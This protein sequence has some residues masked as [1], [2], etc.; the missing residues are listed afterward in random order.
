[1]K[2]KGK[3]PLHMKLMGLLICLTALTFLVSCTVRQTTRATRVRLVSVEQAHMCED[4]CEFLGN[5]TGYSCWFMTR[6]FAHNNALHELQDN[7]VELGATHVFVNRGAKRSL[8]GEAYFC[9]FCKDVDGKPIDSYCLDEEGNKN[10]TVD[11]E[12]CSE[13]EHTWVSKPNSREKCERREG[14]WVPNE[15]MLRREESATIQ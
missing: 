4:E 14:T 5:V 1:M 2:N 9:A 13:K 10:Y 15:D 6:G 12:I 7:A 8:R 11:K 3:A